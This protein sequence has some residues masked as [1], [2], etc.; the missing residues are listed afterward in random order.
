MLARRQ[1]LNTG[2]ALA[3]A[4]A[5]SALAQTPPIAALAAARG[6]LF[7]MMVTREHIEAS[8]T[9]A[10]IVAAQA[11]IIEPGN[12]LKWIRVQ[13]DRDR[14]DFAGADVLMQF[15]VDHQ[16]LTRGHTL[17]WHEALPDWVDGNLPAEDMTA[18]LWTH[19]RT[20][21][22]HTAGRI[23]S[24]DVVNEPIDPSRGGPGGL[25][26]TPFLRALGPGYIELAFRM[27]AEADPKAL[28]TLNDYNLEM[29]TPLHAQRRAAMLELLNRLVQRGVPIHALGIQ[30]HLRP[31]AALFDPDVFRKFI[32]SVASLGLQVFITELDVVDRDL[33][34]DIPSRD[35]ASATL[36]GDYLTAALAEPAVRMVMAWGVSD[37]NTWVNDNPQFARTDGLVARANLYDADFR[38]KPML[39]TLAEVFRAAPDRPRT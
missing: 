13:P 2:A 26:P 19:I 6:V 39:D 14:F 4:P 31:N 7:G 15:A 5:A 9:L 34:A 28:L 18:L 8:R 20:V 22:G 33:P 1:L 24:W 10:E 38:P 17:I 29:D 23:H 35:R 12:E 3:L 25:R 21:A 27:A 16:L 36:L 37:R 30:G 11:R 32:R